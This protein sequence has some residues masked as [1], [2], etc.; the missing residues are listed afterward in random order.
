MKMETVVSKINFVIQSFKS[1]SK[2]KC[3]SKV[4]L[5]LNQ[6]NFIYFYKLHNLI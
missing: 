3:Q 6:Y 4:Y 5:T 2:F 1:K